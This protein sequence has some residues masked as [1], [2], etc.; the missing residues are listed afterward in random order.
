M[1][2][3]PIALAILA[4]PVLAAAQ[5]APTTISYTQLEASFFQFDLETDGI[6]DARPGA[7]NTTGDGDGVS[8]GGSFAIDDL[9][10]LD[11]MFIAARYSDAEYDDGTPY[12]ELMAGLGKY[13]ISESGR[14]SFFGRLNYE[15]VEFDDTEETKRDGYS[16]TGGFRAY[17][18]TYWEIGIGA[19]WVDLG[20]PQGFRLNLST[21][22]ELPYQFFLTA[23]WTTQTLNRNRDVDSNNQQVGDTKDRASNIR[24]GLRKDFVTPF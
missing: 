2:H 5:D 14:L 13:F 11:N 6:D 15:E 16:I 23:D 12:N 20:E 22:I 10:P 17:I 18:D 3:T 19:G 1:R 24:L 9:G 7:V 4:M 21:A 8:Y